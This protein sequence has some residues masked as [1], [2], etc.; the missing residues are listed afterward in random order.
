M[1]IIKKTKKIFFA[2]LCLFLLNE[3]S[4]AADLLEV[5]QQA[6]VS[7]P[8]YLQAISQRLVTA[9]GVPISIASLLPNINLATVPSIK[10][11][12]FSGSSYT[13]DIE[14]QPIMPRN[15]TTRA[16]SL[17]LTATQT[18]FNAAQFFNVAASRAT[19]K[20]AEA[21]LNAALQNLMIRVA[22][23]YFAVLKDEDNVRY[24]EA[25]KKA[26]AEQL[27]QIKQQYNVGLKTITDLYTAQA[28]YDSA[29]AKLIAAQ[30]VLAN[31][32]ENLR[33]IT[34]RYY[35][36]LASL[37]EAFPLITPKPQDSEQWVN[38]ATKQNWSIKAAQYTVDSARI[39]IKQQFSGHFPT[40]NVQG[41]LDRLYSN[42]VN[43]YHSFT[44]R[45]G[46]GTE[47]DKS[48]SLNINFPVFS[49]GLVVAETNQA[50]YQYQVAQQ[51]LEQ[52]VRNTI[53]AARQSYLGVIAGISQIKADKQ[54]IRS[55]KSSLLGMEESYKVGTETLF[56]VLNQQQNVYLAQTQYATDRYAFVNHILSLKQAAGTL[57]FDDL[58]AINAWLVEQTSKK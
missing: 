14:G 9:E 32:K 29:V 41:T 30:T 53:N 43:G 19:A 27:D 57:S 39:F 26:F 12:G 21:T 52:V 35:P 58:R 24:S 6:Q 48:V 46:P 15:I 16:Y 17:T 10:H 47:T 37:S 11:S 51:Q 34:G 40:V 56:D 33:V 55:A 20:A 7:D 54:S 5:Y 44:D 3:L 38:I 25:S 36:H 28:S 8:L 45:N 13:T 1:Q 2:I 22:N 4:H 50:V 42:N 18:I 23:A 49:G 31:D